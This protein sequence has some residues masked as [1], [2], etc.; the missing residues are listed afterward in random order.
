MT[1]RGAD[2]VQSYLDRLFDLMAGTGSAG[3]RALAEAEAH[4]TE[5]V[6]ALTTAGRDRGDAEREAIARFGTPER[7]A[8]EHARGNVASWGLVARRLFGGAWLGLGV[9]LSCA[10]V[11][12]AVIWAVKW[13]FGLKWV[14][15]DAPAQTYGAAR[16]ATLMR[17]WPASVD[18]QSASMAHHLRESI[19]FPLAAMIAGVLVLAAFLACRRVPVLRALTVLPGPG[20]LGAAG[21][22]VF[23]ALA[24]LF[25]GE[26]AY[27][28]GRGG[29][30]G[31]VFS[32]GCAALTAALVF[33]P[34][35]VRELRVRRG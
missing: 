21:A 28:L 15:P 5:A 19:A 33:A 23:G 8:R 2:S 1:D 22:S 26:F 11:S 18:C 10:G 30:W 4:L 3:R 16:C 34:S 12:A 25:L 31:I 24:L 29:A 9:G 32:Y 14:V 20:L 35:L 13:G 27:S 17:E 6:E 7:V